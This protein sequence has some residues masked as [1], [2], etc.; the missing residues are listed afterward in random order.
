LSIHN[1]DIPKDIHRQL[2][3]AE[4]HPHFDL[5]QSFYRIQMSRKL[6]VQNVSDADTHGESKS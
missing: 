5:Y 1:F 6:L 3:R 2:S 4:I